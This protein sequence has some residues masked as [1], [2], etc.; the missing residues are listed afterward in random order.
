MVTTL[1]VDLPELHLGQREIADH[2]AR[3]KVVANGRRYGKTK[4]GVWLCTRT[5]LEGGRTWWVAPTYKIA[6]EGWDTLTEFAR[7]IPG[8]EISKTE[9]EV[10]W[11]G[12]GRTQV[13]SADDPQSLRGAGLDGV[14]LDEAAFIQQEAW[15]QA[16]RPAL[17]DRQGWAL[18]ISTPRGHNWFWELWEQAHQYED[19]AAWRAPTLDN[20]FIPREEIELAR[21]TSHPAAFAQEYEASFESVS[22]M[23]WPHFSRER[24]VHDL[25]ALV[26]NKQVRLAGHGAYGGDFGLVALSTIV[27]VE[28]DSARR[29]WVRECWAKPGGDEP[30]YER[31]RRILEDKYGKWR[32]R[33]DPTQFMVINRYNWAGAAQSAGAR[34]QRQA[35][36]GGLLKMGIDDGP[37]PALCFDKNGRGVMDLVREIELYHLEMDSKGNL[38]PCRES[39]KQDD[40]CTGL[41]YAIEE[42]RGLPKADIVAVKHE[43]TQWRRARI[44]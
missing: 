24:H 7:Q 21:R 30:E 27:V 33:G 8:S 13:R 28:E 6:L 9:K 34:E 14:V 44:A 36:V 15:T 41:E 12:G 40:R 42:L 37:L 20:P 18:F 32:G 5:G 31:A 39:H 38:V 19:W 22:N 4:L 25:Q 16:L 11:P 29:L 10:T 43:A 26:D 1:T 17:S 23:V 35:L 2:P 3:F